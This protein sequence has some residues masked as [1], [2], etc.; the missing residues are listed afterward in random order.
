M[1]IE[2]LAEDLALKAQHDFKFAPCHATMSLIIKNK[3]ARGFRKGNFRMTQVDVLMNHMQNIGSISQ[4]EAMFEYNIQSFHRRL[5]DI[6]A[7]G[8]E[9]QAHPKTNPV[10]GQSYTRYTLVH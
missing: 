10:T 8:H 7:L 3:E 5:S 2:E 9:L 4:R 1:S 6:R